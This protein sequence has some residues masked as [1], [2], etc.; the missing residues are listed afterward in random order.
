MSSVL[1]NLGF[2]ALNKI[3]K[4]FQISSTS[5]NILISKKS[6]D[7]I[8]HIIILVHGV[9]HCGNN[10]PSNF[11]INST[12]IC[13]NC[14]ICVIRNEN[15]SSSKHI[16]AIDTEIKHAPLDH[17]TISVS[18]LMEERANGIRLLKF[19]FQKERNSV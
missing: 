16:A 13:T 4:S 6:Q 17:R 5:I 10:I 14:L 18:F 8:L 12:P 19:S 3:S 1:S 7:L 11:K 9:P 2:F 15:Q